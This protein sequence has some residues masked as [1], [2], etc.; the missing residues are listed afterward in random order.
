MPNKCKVSVCLITYNHAR[1]IRQAVESVLAQ[2]TDF[3]F[4][5][6]IGEDCSTDNTRSIL[7]EL[8]AIYPGRLRLFQRE[9]NIGMGPNAAATYAECHGT[10]VAMLEGDD[11]WTSPKKLQQQV[12]AMD[13]HPQWAVCC[14]A[15]AAINEMG[16]S[17]PLALPTPSRDV[18]TIDDL[19]RAN[20]IQTCTVMYRGGLVPEIPSWLLDL[21]LLDW[22]LHILHARHGTIGYLPDSMAAYRIHAGGA[23]SMKDL[24]YRARAL[25]QMLSRLA[26]HGGE[27]YTDQI[28]AAQVAFA[29]ELAQAA[30]AGQTIKRTLT[31]RVGEAILSPAA[32]AARCL[33]VLRRQPDQARANHNVTAPRTTAS[34]NTPTTLTS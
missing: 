25:T 11:Y 14:H 18:C 21:K 9:R 19:L 1:F 16:G 34:A 3:L 29:A 6:V 13:A 23:W 30:E 17:D 12:D 28:E 26:R 32:L 15:A 31:F 22:P 8:D 33:G 27:A 24:E 4:E 7:R 5:I 20:F 2:Q 10:Y